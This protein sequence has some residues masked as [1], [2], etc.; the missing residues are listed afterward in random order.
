VTSAAETKLLAERKLPPVIELGCLTLAFAIAGVIYL[1]AHVPGEPALWPAVLLLA[2]GTLVELGN[3]VVLV[4]TR[5]FAWWMFWRVWRWVLL[6]YVVIAGMLMYT[7]IYDSIPGGQLTLMLLTLALFAVDVP[8]MLAFSV[9]RF[10]PPDEPAR[11][12]P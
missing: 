8:T 7:F 4:R 12:R 5:P 9:A 10:Q 3:V 6:A 11:T 1:A 2:L